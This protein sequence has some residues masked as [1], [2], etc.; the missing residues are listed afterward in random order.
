MPPSTKQLLVRDIPFFIAEIIMLLP[1]LDV[2]SLKPY[3]DAGVAF[4]LA[5]C[6]ASLVTLSL[7]KTRGRT[8]YDLW[9]G[10]VVVSLRAADLY[11]A[12]ASAPKA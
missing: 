12:Q 9:A 4:Y 6:L 10:T 3:D 7:P 2:Q 11:H 1:F 5:V 8:L